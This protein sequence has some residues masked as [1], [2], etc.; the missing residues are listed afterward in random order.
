MDYTE[1][2]DTFKKTAL[3]G[4]D[5]S[6]HEKKNPSNSV[7]RQSLDSFIASALDEQNPTELL[8][9]SG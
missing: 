8:Q 7:V 5:W 3:R 6:L 1:D 9:D 4:R 2:R